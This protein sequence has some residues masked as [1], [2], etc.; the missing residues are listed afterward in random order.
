MDCE[1]HTKENVDCDYLSMSLPQINYVNKEGKRPLVSHIDGFPWERFSH[2]WP[3]VCYGR[4]NFLGLFDLDYHKTKQ[5]I[6]ARIQFDW[7]NI[8]Q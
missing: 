2:Y 5:P 4:A 1:L 8:R 3:F 6:Y 7:S